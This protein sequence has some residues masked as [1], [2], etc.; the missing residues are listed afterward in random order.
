MITD[1]DV[2]KLKETFAT[3]KD[4]NALSTKVDD[5]TVKVDGLQEQVGGLTVK[6]DSLETR[7]DALETRVEVGF[8]RMEKR[9]DSLEGDVKDIKQTMNHMSNVLDF[10]AGAYQDSLDEHRAGSV[11]LARHDR[12]I[13]VLA[14]AAGV[15][16]PD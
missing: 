14:K 13:G 11:I 6:V 9:M 4:H 15:A 2:E 1:G 3:K 7:I 12:Q 5:L 8:N 10:V 16:L